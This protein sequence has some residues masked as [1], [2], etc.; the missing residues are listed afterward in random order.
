MEN[1]DIINLAIGISILLMSVVIHE[2]AHAVMA[3]MLGD[4]TARLNGRITLN[5][6]AHLDPVGSVLVPILAFFTSGFIFGWA[7]PVGFNPYNLKNRKRDEALIAAA[8]PLSNLALVAVFVLLM[9]LALV[10]GTGLSDN[11]VAIVWMII[12]INLVLAFF[13]LIPIP[14]L[15]GS[16]VFFSFLPDSLS[17]LR[18]FMEKYSIILLVILM[19]SP[20]TG[21]YISMAMSWAI[22]FI[23]SLLSF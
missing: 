21:H 10:S 9:K 16:K 6:L 2:V 12:R 23:N 15:D 22:D 4:P 11:F 18:D 7:K 13:N 5:P 17:G 20:L 8:G 14:P 19:V 1:L 3:D